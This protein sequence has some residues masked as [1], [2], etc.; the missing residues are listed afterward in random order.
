MNQITRIKFNKIFFVK[1]ENV[2]WQDEN[3][4]IFKISDVYQLKPTVSMHLTILA[5][6]EQLKN[7]FDDKNVQ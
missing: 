3:N 2:T 1:I 7:V 5:S 4:I 6:K